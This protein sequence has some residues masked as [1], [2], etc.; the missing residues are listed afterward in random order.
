VTVISG[1]RFRQRSTNHSCYSIPEL[2][3]PFLDT[4]I[5]KIDKND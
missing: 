1:R 2:K 3:H 5:K 4:D